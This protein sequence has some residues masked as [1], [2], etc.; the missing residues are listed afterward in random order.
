MLNRGIWG[1]GGFILPRKEKYMNCDLYLI[2]WPCDPTSN[3]GEKGEGVF[4]ELFSNL[5]SFL[6]PLLTPI[7]TGILK[8]NLHLMLLW[9]NE[10]ADA[11]YLGHMM[12]SLE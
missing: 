7:F 3:G 12:G 1:S 8:T 4:V 6:V 5:S 2:F 10:N 11:D 9:G